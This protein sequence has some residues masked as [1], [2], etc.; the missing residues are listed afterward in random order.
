MRVLLIE[1]DSNRAEELTALFSE[2]NMQVHLVATPDDALAAADEQ[3]FCVIVLEEAVDSASGVDFVQQ[4]RQRGKSTPIMVLVDTDD[5]DLT[6]QLLDVGADDILVRPFTPEV[7]LAQ[8]RSLLRRCEPGESAVLKYEDLSLDLRSLEVQ[9]AETRIGCTSRELAI[10]EYLMRHPQRVISRAELSEAIWDSNVA[11]ESNVI[12]VFFA[13]L[14]RK[15]DRPF[16][17]PLIHTLVGRGYMLSVTRIGA[18]L[19]ET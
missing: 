18:V 6:V 7:M 5:P 14:R 2:Q 9:R 15:I 12:E 3:S 19:S 16:A 17:V 1:Q 13:R 11:P 4:F 10:L 8:I